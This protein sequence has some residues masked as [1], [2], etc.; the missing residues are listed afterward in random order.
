MIGT[1]G[2]ERTWIAFS[3]KPEKSVW[4]QVQVL[5]EGKPENQNAAMI[6][7]F[8]ECIQT[9]DMNQENRLAE[10]YKMRNLLS[11]FE[12]K[13]PRVSAVEAHFAGQFHKRVLDNAA[14]EPIVALVG[15]RE[16]IFSGKVCS[17]SLPSA[18]VYSC[19]CILDPI[20]L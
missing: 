15:F 10:A 13:R 7:C 9:V 19:A 8:G 18:L 11:E 5:G 12:P 3:N 6:Y 4:C 2:R 1:N 20:V 17:L 14:K 16:W